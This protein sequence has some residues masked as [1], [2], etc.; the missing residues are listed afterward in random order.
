MPVPQKVDFLVE[1]ASCPFIKGLLT[2]VQ[3]LNFNRLLLLAPWVSTPGG[4]REDQTVPPFFLG[5]RGDYGG[6]W[7]QTAG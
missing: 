4:F 1:R 3:H 6:L 7:T 5:V 2:M